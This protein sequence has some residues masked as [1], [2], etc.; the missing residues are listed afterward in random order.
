[1]IQDQKVIGNLVE[2]VAVALRRVGCRVG[3]CTHL[4]IEHSIAQRLNR[5][6]LRRSP[7]DADAEVAGAKL[8]EG[9]VVDVSTG[10]ELFIRQRAALPCSAA[11]SGS[12]DGP[13]IRR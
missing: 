11:G 2:R 12:W 3:S 1:M 6:D 7:R 8:R 5:I 4:A 13:S 10:N 9:D